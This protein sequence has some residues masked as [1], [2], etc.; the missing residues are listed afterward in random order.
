[1]SKHRARLVEP[2]KQNGMIRSRP[3]TVLSGDEHLRSGKRTSSPLA[4]TPRHDEEPSKQRHVDQ[5]WHM[6]PLD[7]PMLAGPQ[8][9]HVA[10][11]EKPELQK[12]NSPGSPLGVSLAWVFEE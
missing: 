3:G 10:R 2:V 7:E 12:A 8:G 4:V 6:I 1:M 9:Q 5:P 11:P